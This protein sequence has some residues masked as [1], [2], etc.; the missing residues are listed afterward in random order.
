MVFIKILVHGFISLF[1]LEIQ[2]SVSEDKQD[3]PGG[4]ITKEL[5]GILKSKGISVII[6]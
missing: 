5:E 2:R 4:S 1:V 6:Q 3:S